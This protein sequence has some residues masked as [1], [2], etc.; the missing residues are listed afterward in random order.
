MIEDQ[1]VAVFFSSAS[2]GHFAKLTELY[3]YGEPED[4][5]MVYCP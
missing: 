1:L 2:W 3:E 5:S 4:P